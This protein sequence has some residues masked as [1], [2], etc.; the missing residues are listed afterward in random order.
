ML[1]AFKYLCKNSESRK[2]FKN[3]CEH[4]TI[5]VTV[6]SQIPR[7]SKHEWTFFSHECNDQSLEADI[8]THFPPENSAFQFLAAYPRR[9]TSDYIHL[10]KYSIW[11]RDSDVCVYIIVWI[12]ISISFGSV[13]Y[14]RIPLFGKILFVLRSRSAASP[15]VLSIRG[16]R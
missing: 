13:T 1:T 5:R 8:S 2:L 16:Y 10:D 6:T 11:L 7:A 15:K 9:R 14:F 12:V 4:E 3:H